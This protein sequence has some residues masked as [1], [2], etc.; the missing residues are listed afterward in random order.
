MSEVHR[1]RLR[2]PWQA[3]PLDA[4]C[5]PPTRMQVPCSWRDAGWIGF[6]GR[7]RH[8]RLFGWPPLTGDERVWLVVDG[9]TGSG[10]VRLNGRELGPI[11]GAFRC[12]VT[13]MLQERNGIEIDVAAE[14]D[15]GGVTGEVRLEIVG[16]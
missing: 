1:I 6:A 11:A 2:G 12:D 14:S 5:P 8:E 7:A 4:E 9:I 13:E 3:T 10:Q 15:L 16:A